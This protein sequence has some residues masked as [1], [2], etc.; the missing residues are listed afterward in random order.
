[1]VE[2]IIN[3]NLASSNG[4]CYGPFFWAAKFVGLERLSR[5][6]SDQTWSRF[7]NFFAIVRSGDNFYNA[8]LYNMHNATH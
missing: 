1:M 6:L 8:I 2:K 3:D 5:L 4:H 7:V